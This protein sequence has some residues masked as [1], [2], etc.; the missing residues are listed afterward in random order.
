M[1]SASADDATCAGRVVKRCLAKDPEN[2]GRL[3]AISAKN[4]KWIAEGGSQAT[5]CAS[6]GTPCDVQCGPGRRQRCCCCA[7]SLA[8]LYFQR[9][10]PEAPVLRHDH[11]SARNTTFSGPHQRSEPAGLL[12]PDGKRIVFGARNSHGNRPQL[13]LRSLEQ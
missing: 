7:L 2:A 12:A 5:A 13:W 10:A 6:A 4:L 1:M 8:F 3:S 11:S 9:D